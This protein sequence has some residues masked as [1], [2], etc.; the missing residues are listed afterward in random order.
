[1]KRLLHAV[2]LILLVA[3]TD[4]VGAQR[5]TPSGFVTPPQ[6]ARQPVARSIATRAEPG[7]VGRMMLRGL[8]L[9]AVAAI[10]GG[11]AGGRLNRN[12]EV[13]DDTNEEGLYWGAAMGF[14]IGS[15]T[16][17]H[18]ASEHGGS[19]GLGVALNVVMG[20]AAALAA[21]PNNS[22]LPLLLI[23]P[24]QLLVPIIVELNGIRVGR[25]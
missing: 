6:P 10:A 9:G 16:G 1:V 17:V 11:Y 5:M 21:V 25:R 20:A 24:A 22:A 4:T 2:A 13:N 12:G 7:E 14:A 15:A 18:N 8:T 23:A 19:L 3:R